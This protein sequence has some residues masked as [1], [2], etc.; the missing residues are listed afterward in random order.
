MGFLCIIFNG[1][2]SVIYLLLIYFT[3]TYFHP[4]AKLFLKLYFYSF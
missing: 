3:H 1:F 4:S 2:F